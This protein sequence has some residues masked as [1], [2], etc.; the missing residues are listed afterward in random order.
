MSFIKTAVAASGMSLATL[1]GALAQGGPEPWDK[2]NATA[3]KMEDN[4]RR[5]KGDNYTVVVESGSRNTYVYAS[6]LQND[7]NDARFIVPAV[8]SK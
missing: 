2:A 5:Y 6:V 4:F 8:T 3:Q 1:T 7:T